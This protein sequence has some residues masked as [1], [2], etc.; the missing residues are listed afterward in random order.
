MNAANATNQG[1][2][3]GHRQ[4]LQ[5]PLRSSLI[6]FCSSL[7]QCICNDR[8][9]FWNR[10]GVGRLSR[11]LRGVAVLAM[12]AELLDTMRRIESVCKVP[13]GG[14]ERRLLVSRVTVGIYIERRSVADGVE[15]TVE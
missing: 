14:G 15:S 1:S 13:Q 12:P 2:R 8:A 9:P 5:L 4:W 11:L 10:D 7:S 6:A 3:S